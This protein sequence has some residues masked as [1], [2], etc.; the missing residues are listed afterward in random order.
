MRYLL[1]SACLVALIGCASD[2]Q[3]LQKTADDISCADKIKPTHL[4]TAWYT[5]SVDVYDKHISGLLLIKNMPD[6]SVRVVF[7][8]EAG[9]TFFDF[10]FLLDGTFKVYS[11]VSQ[12]KKKA[13]IQTLRKDFELILGIPFRQGM[14]ERWEGNEQVFFGV[15][16][17]KETA[18]FI[19]SKDCASLRNIELGSMRKRKVSVQVVGSYP[20]PEGF[21]ITHLLF[22]MKLKLTYLLKE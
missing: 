12:L 3:F 15:K 8:N 7:T 19:T 17:K 16:Q 5:T 14:I 6:S 21:E 22:D 10:G 1:F 11:I 20:S 4:S 18:Y 13:V 2:Y 9:V